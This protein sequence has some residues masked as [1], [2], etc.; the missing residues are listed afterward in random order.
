VALYERAII[1][2]TLAKVQTMPLNHPALRSAIFQ[3]A[4]NHSL[5]VSP[6]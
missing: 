5:L 1:K 2:L 3:I 6:Y 4:E